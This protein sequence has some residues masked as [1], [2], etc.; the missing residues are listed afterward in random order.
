MNV[1]TTEQSASL[2]DEP[3]RSS[4]QFAAVFV[5]SYPISEK[6][7]VLFCPLE[8]LCHIIGSICARIKSAVFVIEDEVVES[9]V[10]RSRA[11]SVG[12]ETVFALVAFVLALDETVAPS[13]R[14]Q[15]IPIRAGI[16]CKLTMNI[17]SI[18]RVQLES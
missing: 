4:L 6:Q 7:N 17:A 1:V 11:A 18:H 8:R 16:R 2:G 14:Q 5:A 13:L 10:E 12:G 9:C 3:I 15:W